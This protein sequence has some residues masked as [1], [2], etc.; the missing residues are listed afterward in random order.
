MEADWG[1][2]T[3][4]A[5]NTI[6]IFAPML[7][8]MPHPESA[9]PDETADTDKEDCEIVLTIKEA[10]DVVVRPTLQDD[11]GDL[12]FVQFCDDSGELTL[13]LQGSCEGCP[14]SSDD[15]LRDQIFTVN[16]ST[17]MQ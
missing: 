2:I 4:A 6:G 10:I 15:T 17:A 9:E 5:A 16:P 1:L 11:G 12:K 7:G 14:S 3:G 13:E 8:A